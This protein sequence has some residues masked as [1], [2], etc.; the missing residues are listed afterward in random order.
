MAKKSGTGKLTRKSAADIPRSSA[1]D[2]KRLRAAMRGTIDTGDIPERRKIDRVERDAKGK[3]PSRSMIRDAVAQEMQR[4][5]LSVY[6]LWKLAQTHFPPLAQSAVH[7]FL[8]GH[9]QLELPIIEALLTAMDMQIV[10]PAS[11]R[12]RQTQ[13][14]TKKT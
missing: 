8:E 4:R 10:G 3:L 11:S 14:A 9:G 1:A 5:D 6:R 13:G 12:Q 2:L 7:E